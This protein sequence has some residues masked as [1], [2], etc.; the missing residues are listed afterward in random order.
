[1]IVDNPIVLSVFRSPGRCE[2]CGRWFPKTDAAH[3]FSVGAG[4]L[5]VYENLVSLC[6]ECHSRNH[7]G[8][9]SRLQLL[10]VVGQ[11]ECLLVDDIEELVYRLRRMP[12]GSE[13]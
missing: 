9:I 6:R 13:L 2:W 7:S 10:I 12:K 8:E 11:R 3:C 5:D 4:R 1:M